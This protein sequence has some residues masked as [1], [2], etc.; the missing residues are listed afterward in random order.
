MSFRSASILLISPAP[1][2]G[3]ET[4]RFVGH[5]KSTGNA[6]KIER[7]STI[8]SG[9]DIARSAH[10][11]RGGPHHCRLTKTSNDFSCRADEVSVSQFLKSHFQYEQSHSKQMAALHRACHLQVRMFRGGQ[12]EGE[13][14]SGAD[15]AD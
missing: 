8:E 14:I 5:V 3:E 6:G 4:Y 12:V 10:R 1:K 9:F 7:R 15:G 13:L 11:R 2:C